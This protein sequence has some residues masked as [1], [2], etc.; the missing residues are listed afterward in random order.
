MR[1]TAAR[2]TN[3]QVRA[4]TEACLTSDLDERAKVLWVFLWTCKGGGMGTNSLARVL[5]MPVDD[6]ETAIAVLRERGVLR[7]KNGT[8]RA[9]PFEVDVRVEDTAE[10]Q[11]ASSSPAHAAALS[12]LA[13]YDEVR[14]GHGLG[15]LMDRGPAL[16]HF[17]AL[18]GWLADHGVTFDRFLEWAIERTAFMRDRMKFPTTS[19]LAGPWLRGEWLNGVDGHRRD[20]S[21][22]T[23][24]HAGQSYRDPAGLKERLVA[25]GFT[26]AREFG[27]AT[28][29]HILD[30]A[31]NMVAL[32]D[33]FD[34]PDPDYA[35]EIEWLRDRLAKEGEGASAA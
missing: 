6:V 28:L 3:T 24:G 23:R 1:P 19:L 16:T 17:R 31:E 20:P 14:I 21:K 33:H 12:I 13:H 22:A 15:P 5:Q 25:A 8:W 18:A 32:P 11:A 2:R 4:Q 27:K 26:R 29:R 35:D 7:R 30:W 34:Q 9:S 10:I